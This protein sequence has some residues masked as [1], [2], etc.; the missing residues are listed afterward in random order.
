MAAT[1]FNAPSVHK[2]GIAWFSA[3]L[4]VSGTHLKKPEGAP[5]RSE[6][7]AW[8]PDGYLLP[9]HVPTIQPPQPTDPGPTTDTTDH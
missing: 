7:K 2:T 4:Q 6:T 8:A 3:D 9:A 5:S 1:G